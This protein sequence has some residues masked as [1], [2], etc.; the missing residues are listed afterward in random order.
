M[1]LIERV[2]YKFFQAAKP[3]I[4]SPFYIKNLDT[5]CKNK[6]NKTISVAIPHYQRGKKIHV[7]LKNI[8]KDSRI[9]EIVILDDGSSKEEFHELLKNLS[10]FN[11]KIKLFRREKNIGPFRTKIQ[12]V[13][14]CSNEWVILLDSD[15]SIFRKYIDA[16][17]KLSTWDQNTIY[18]P[19]FAY[20]NFDFRGLSGKVIDFEKSSSFDFQKFAPFMNDGNYFLHKENFLNTLLPY[21]NFKALADVI[22]ANYIWLS[23]GNKLEILTNAPYFHR[24][25]PGSIW[26]NTADESSKNAVLVGGLLVKGIKADKDNLSKLLDILPDTWVEPTPIPLGTI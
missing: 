9:N 12:A 7:T 3:L 24:V 15:N 20:P 10:R 6:F 22:F 8:L 23:H 1:Q 2:K 18:C 4:F 19:D 11:S 17:F 26:L 13:S 21:K 16:I 5:I 25:H 14:L